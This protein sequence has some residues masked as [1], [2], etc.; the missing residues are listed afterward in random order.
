[1]SLNIQHLFFRYKP[2]QPLIENL[3]L[4]IEPGQ[5]VALTGVSGCG[6]STLIQLLL[7]TLKP[8]QGMISFNQVILNDD[9]Q[10]LPPQARGIG[11]VFQDYALFPHLTV[12]QNVGFGLKLKSMAKQTEIDR[13]LKVFAL[14]DVAFSFPHQLSGGQMQRV[15]IA[16]ALA[17]KP[18]LLLMDEP[19]SNL[20]AKLAERIRQDLK[21]LFKQLKMT[22]LLVTHH[23]EDATHIADQIIDFSSLN[24]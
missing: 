4:K 2:T 15:A 24:H 20:D 13:W 21:P 19:F 6:K 18:S 9:H 1:M 23:R 16:R 11:V 12:R 5:I 22:V 17:P 14:G 7:G 3:S 10:F 8:K